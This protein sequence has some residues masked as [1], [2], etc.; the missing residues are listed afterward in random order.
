M[1]Q[2]CDKTFLQNPEKP[3][4]DKNVTK[5]LFNYLKNYIKR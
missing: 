3:K 2:K 5:P 4:C 1:C